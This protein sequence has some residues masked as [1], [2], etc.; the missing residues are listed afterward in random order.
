MRERE[1]TR[2]R[3]RGLERKGRGEGKARISVT[4]YDS[5]DLLVYSSVFFY[6]KVTLGDLKG[7]SK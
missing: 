6:C 1:R 5:S 2:E 7:A 3:E 4:D